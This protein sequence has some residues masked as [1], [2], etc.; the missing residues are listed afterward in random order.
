ML[1]QIFR[2]KCE[3]IIAVNAVQDTEITI[4]DRN[5]ILKLILHVDKDFYNQ[6]KYHENHSFS[7]GDK[8]FAPV[9]VHQF[10]CIPKNSDTSNLYKIITP[11]DAAEEIETMY[12]SFLKSEFLE[13]YFDIS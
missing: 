5:F 8:F 13:G 1:E 2:E 11:R 3:T 9:N 7:F 12:L 6:I 4:Q 10:V